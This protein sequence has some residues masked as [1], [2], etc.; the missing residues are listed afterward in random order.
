MQFPLAGS[1]GNKG[2]IAPGRWWGNERAACAKIFISFVRER[3]C[4]SL[5]IRIIWGVALMSSFFFSPSEWVSLKYCTRGTNKNLLKVG[6]RS[7][8]FCLFGA[9]KLRFIL[10][11]DLHVRF[12]IGLVTYI[13]RL[14]CLISGG[15][16]YRVF[17]KTNTLGHFLK[18]FP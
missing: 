18:Y 9:N 11:S 3:I 10:V 12:W 6:V 8:L 2:P 4:H 16:L 5:L 7:S 1:P 15:S 17:Q 14:V 13:F